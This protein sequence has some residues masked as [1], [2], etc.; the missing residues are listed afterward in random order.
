VYQT[1][2]GTGSWTRGQLARARVV[3]N[4]E[5]EEELVKVSVEDVAEVRTST[6]PENVLRTTIHP[7]KEIEGSTF[8]AEGSYVFVPNIADEYHGL[9]LKMVSDSDKAFVGM[10]KVRT[11]EGFWRLTTWRNQIV[12]QKLL[13][14]DEVT[15]LEG[16]SVELPQEHYDAAMQMIDRVTVDFDASQYRNA[17]RERSEQLDAELSGSELPREAPTTPVDSLLSILEGFGA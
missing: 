15:E 6:L 14:P 3:L 7:R 9:V 1:P 4:N 16:V 12:V 17:Y 2:E 13:W 10:C 8:F 11:T 5:G